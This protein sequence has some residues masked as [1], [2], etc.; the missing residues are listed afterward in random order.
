MQ[1][2]DLI[3]LYTRHNWIK[4]L[5]NNIC[6]SSHS[7]IR[8]KGLAGSLPAILGAALH[9]LNNFTQIFI[10][11]DKEAAAYLYTDLLNLLGPQKIVLY[12]AIEYQTD[13]KAILD[14]AANLMRNEILQQLRK[15]NKSSKIIVTYPEAIVTKVIS[16]DSL[17]ENSWSIQPRGKLV[18]SEFVDT[19]IDKGFEKVDFVYEAGQFAIRG[20]IIDVFSYGS[21]LPYRV[22]LLGNE[23]ESIRLFN[24]SNQLSTEKVKEAIL[25]SYTEPFNTTITYQSFFDYLPEESVVWLND[26]EIVINALKN[27]REELNGRPQQISNSATPNTTEKVELDKVLY[28]HIE[29]WEKNIRKFTCVEFG[30]RFYLESEEVIE[31]KASSQ[32]SFNQQLSL[33]AENLQQNQKL[34]L[35]NLILAES[36]SQFER[37]ANMLEELDIKVQF[38]ALPIGISQG[39]IDHQIGIACYTEHQIFGRYYRYKSPQKYFKSQAFTLKELN[40]LQPGDYVVH[41]DHGIARFSGL[42]RVSVN[43]KVQE[44]LRLVYKDNDVVYLSLH[45]LHKISKYTGKEGIV[46]TMSK[47]GSGAWEQKKSKVK[48]KVQVIAK[49]LIQLYSKRKYAP[50]F[51][52]SKDTFLQAEMESSFIY[53][54]TPDQ[55]SATAD[56]KKDMEA[57]HPMDRLVCGDVGFG[58]TEVAIRAAFKAVYDRKQVAILVP[59]TIL[60]LQHYESFKNRLSNFPVDVKY[61]NRFKSKQEIKKIQEAAAQGKIDILIGTHTI[62]GKA[63]E[64]KDLGLLVVDEEQKFGVKAKD[65][66][67]ELKVNVDVLTL[68]ATPIPRTLHFSL[69][70]AR[71]LSIIATPPSNRQ[72]VQTSIHTFDKKI[73]QDAIHYEVQRGGQVFFVHN[74]IN[75]IQEIANM[76]YKLVP[77]Y[78][79]GIAHGQMDGDQLEKKML[80]FIAGGYDIL[81]S[82]NI[83]ESGLDIPNANTIIINDSHMFG[84]SDLHQMRGRVGRSNKK[85]FC[86]LI[87][88]PNSSLTEEARKRL[89]T[90]EEFTE[91]GDGFKVAMRDLDI[92]GAGNLLGAEQSG[93]IADVGFEAYCKI[94]DEAVQELKE[95]EF[96]ELFAEELARKGQLSNI[97]CTL[98]TDLELLIPTSYVNNDTERLRLYTKLDNIENEKDLENFQV[99]IQ[100]RFGALPTAVQEL[101]KAVKLRWVAKKLCLQKIRLKD[102]I[103]RCYFIP[104]PPKTVFSETLNCILNY[105]QEHPQRCQ[106]K[107]LK[108]QLS[109]TIHAIN[110]V[111][112]A[113]EILKCL[114]NNK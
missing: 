25:L 16:Q 92:R 58:K 10:L 23:I 3:S 86:Y 106:L 83:I 63:F 76:L 13:S 113:Y 70:G 96:K 36:T 91:L 44:V 24:P 105:I 46:P 29:D 107:E 94:L 15:N 62:L 42:S 55:A 57:P 18:L 9:Q 12:P 47:L 51:A 108:N 11:Q 5:L 43:D 28:E 14:T 90:L 93:F 89:S 95:N 82:T 53:E 45:A 88:P 56:V 67:K 35:E 8:L 50:G 114:W 77:E 85:A 104:S 48:H 33:L 112:E 98:E 41:I 100:D 7:F 4:E 74:R 49:E 111:E 84:L 72:P 101:I 37:L 73:I 69:M 6:N 110:T 61:V 20:G 39:Y 21:Q 34:G 1:A 65:R 26:Y 19:L 66:I 102:N 97:D 27:K 22:E 2:K 38:K 40:N 30:N 60:A 32:P 54:D 78:R 99:E 79:I 59:T 80:T 87:A 109:L 103:M 52:F 17:T 68:T 81:V 71:D 31:Y 64:F 75:N